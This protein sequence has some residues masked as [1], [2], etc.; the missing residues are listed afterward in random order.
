MYLRWVWCCTALYRSP[1]G[2]SCSIVWPSKFLVFLRDLSSWSNL[3]SLV[4]LWAMK[5][6]LSKEPVAIGSYR[7]SSGHRDVT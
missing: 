5:A 1:L 7:T 3:V 6:Q 4:Y 2:V